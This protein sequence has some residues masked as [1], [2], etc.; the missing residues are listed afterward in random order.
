M[1]KAAQAAFFAFQAA[2]VVLFRHN[3]AELNNKVPACTLLI[4][5][6]MN[7]VGIPQLGTQ[8]PFQFPS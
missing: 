1:E 5:N 2:W 8:K 7:C 3:Y 6:S 4:A